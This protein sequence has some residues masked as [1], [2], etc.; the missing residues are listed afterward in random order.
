MRTALVNC[1]LL[2]GTSQRGRPGMTVLL[3]DGLIADVAPRQ[4]DFPPDVQ[5]QEVSGDVVMPGLIDCHIHFALWS[6]DLLAHQDQHISYLCGTTFNA[7]REA[8]R[9]GCTAARDP[10]GLDA[11]FRDAVNNG[12]ASGPRVQT[13]V[14]I[15]SPINGICD[16]T[17]SQGLAVPYLPGMPAPE[18]TGPTEARAKVREVLRAGADFIKI[19]TTGGVSSS[20]R[21]PRQQLFSEE[22]V[23]AIVDEAH[24]WGVPVACHALGGPG[25]LMAVRCGVDSI[26]H[27]VWLDTATIEEMVKRRTWYV[28]TLS[29]YELHARRGRPLQQVRAAEITLS[30]AATV[31]KA[32]EAGVRIACGSDSGVYGFGFALELEL[33]VATGMSPAEAIAA[34]TSR[35]AECLGWQDEIGRIHPGMKADL[36]I[37]PGD[38]ILDITVLQNSES[39]SVIKSGVAVR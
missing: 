31:R 25:A 4:H 8:L 16:G 20:R 21:E 9:G 30:H 39:L 10:G 7:L 29:A 37:V 13:S 23:L 28:P 26:E 14:T 17:K 3:D 11:G 24:T 35:A 15:V 12:V 18:C 38:P 1:T 32:R 19:A 5:I 2:D 36:L 22:E 6:L 34:A 27:G 33:L